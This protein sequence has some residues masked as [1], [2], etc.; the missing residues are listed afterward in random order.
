MYFSYDGVIK[1]TET[2]FPLISIPKQNFGND[3]KVVD[4]LRRIE[5]HPLDRQNLCR[6]PI[7]AT[8][9]VANRQVL[10]PQPVFVLNVEGMLRKRWFLSPPPPI[11][12]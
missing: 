5:N 10:G 8:Q 4:P 2:E 12:K 6:P 9:P 7:R 3:F 1:P 11:Q